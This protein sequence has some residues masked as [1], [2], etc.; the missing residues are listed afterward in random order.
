MPRPT[1][2]L[3]SQC[4]GLLV[5]SAPTPDLPA[6]LSESEGEVVRAVLRGHSNA[7]IARQRGT[8][9]KTIANQLYRIYRKLGVCARDELVAQLT[10][11]RERERVG[12]PPGEPDGPASS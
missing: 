6:C 9:A 5:I 12:S 10:G 1:E 7:Q 3:V 2:P 11:P 4:A 8:S